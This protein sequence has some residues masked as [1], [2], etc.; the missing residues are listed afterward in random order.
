MPHG[1]GPTKPDLST[2]EIEFSFR[3]RLLILTKSPHSKGASQP[4]QRFSVRVDQLHLN[5]IEPR[6]IQIPNSRLRHWNAKR[7]KVYPVLHLGR[8]FRLMVPVQIPKATQGPGRGLISL[9]L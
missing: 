3:F 5:L 4:I 7:E 1:V 8:D 9:L 2:I 6:A